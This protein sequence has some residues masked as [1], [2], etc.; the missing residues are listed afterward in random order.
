[1]QGAWPKAQPTAYPPLMARAAA[2][3]L[4][5]VSLVEWSQQY[6][7]NVWTS[8]RSRANG[9]PL[10]QAKATLTAQPHWRDTPDAQQF[11]PHLI[12]RRFGNSREC[13]WP[14]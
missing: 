6:K 2:Q 14:H 11:F 5:H 13:S 3:W 8:V 12:G 4:I 9:M 1:M 10:I 7:Q